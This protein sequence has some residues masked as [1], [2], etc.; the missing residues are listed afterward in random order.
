M[1]AC[2]LLHARFPILA[3]VSNVTVP[4]TKS[5]QKNCLILSLCGKE[6]EGNLQFFKMFNKSMEM[7]SMVEKKT[8]KS[9]SF[10]EETVDVLP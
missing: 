8:Y 5:V 4:W 3:G 2:L 10:A 6:S 7:I 9:E 1:L